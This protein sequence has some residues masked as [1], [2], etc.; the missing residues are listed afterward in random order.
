MKQCQGMNDGEVK[1]HHIYKEQKFSF[2]SYTFT[3]KIDVPVSSNCPMNSENLDAIMSYKSNF[4]MT[5]I[6]CIKT[7]ISVA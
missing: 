6:I 2:M 3:I 4:R 5:K 7:R 1:R